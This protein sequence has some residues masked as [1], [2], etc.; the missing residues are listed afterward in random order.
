MS[1]VIV[2][3]ILVIDDSPED[4][5][6]VRRLLAGETGP[7]YEIEEATSGAEGLRALRAARFDCLLLDN[8]LP[9]CDGL[10]FLRELSRFFA[11]ETMI[12]VVVLTGQTDE[13]LINKALKGGAQD[14]LVK[15][16]F[17]REVLRRS[18]NDSVVRVETRRELDRLHRQAREAIRQ[19]DEALVQQRAIETRLR[20][21]LDLIQTV[22]R[23][24]TEGL[25]MID[26]QGRLTFLNPAAE[27]ILGESESTLLGSP[28]PDLWTQPA[29]GARSTDLVPC[30]WV[31]TNQAVRDREVI[32]PRKSGERMPIAFSSTPILTDGVMVGTV[33]VLRDVTEQRRIDAEMERRAA[34]LTDAARRKDEFLAMIAHELRNPLAPILNA[35]RII[36]LRG[37]TDAAEERTRAMVEQQVRHMNRLI[38]D[39]LDMSRISRGTIQLRPEPIRFWPTPSTGLW[40]RSATRSMPAGKPCRC[41]CPTPPSGSI[42]DPTR[43][44]QILTNLLTN[45]AKYTDPNGRIRLSATQEGGNAEIRIVDNGVGIA[46]SFLPR[47]FDLFAQADRSLDRS[48]GGLGIGLTLVR[49]LVEL[50]GGSISVRSEGLGM[51]SEFIVRLPSRAE[52]SAQPPERN[53]AGSL[54]S[55]RSPVA[56]G[57]GRRRQRPGRRRASPSSCSSGGTTCWSPTTVPSALDAAP[58]YRPEVVLLDIGLP[59]WSTAI[60]VAEQIRQLPVL[61]PNRDPGHDRATPPRTIAGGPRRPGSSATWSSRS[62]STRWSATS[63][64]F[65]H[66]DDLHDGSLEQTSSTDELI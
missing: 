4:R 51:G 20:H 45:A 5:A 61:R 13:A 32:L 46:A 47:I 24:T 30:D 36:G 59:Q 27:S 26:R 14:F 33:V 50:H 8:Y 41:R 54:P 43:L 38:D 18:I 66:A 63:S 55:D 64:E 37:G 19:K 17:T 6:A 39:L 48:Q 11:D 22:A 25:C 42:A 65:A 58:I 23:T 35:M 57:A 2:R 28:L 62:T 60:R 12:P 53:S 15:G 9:D 10:E 49:D 1:Q 16:R 29:P 56:P 21:Q 7:C 34:E 52:T 3:R 40:N 31:G 44:D